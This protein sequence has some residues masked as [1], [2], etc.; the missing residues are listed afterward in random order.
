[1]LE[2]NEEALALKAQ[3]TRI[4]IT[5]SNNDPGLLRSGSYIRRTTNQKTKY[6]D[7]GHNNRHENDSIFYDKAADDQ[8]SRP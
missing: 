5:N 2:P 4:R 6:V 1:M 3:N 7:N 8:A